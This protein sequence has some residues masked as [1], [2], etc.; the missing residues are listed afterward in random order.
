MNTNCFAI[1][2]DGHL[3]A[4]EEQA[5]LEAWR[6]RTYPIWIDFEG[7]DEEA[8]SAW[9]DQLGLDDRL[10]DLLHTG[11]LANK[12]LPTREAVFFAYPVALRGSQDHPVNFACLCL[13]GL[14]VTMQDESVDMPVLKA[15]VKKNY[16]LN[17]PSTSGLVCTALLLQSVSLRA[18]ALQLR[19]QS[20]VLAERMDENPDSVSLKEILAHKK[21]VMQL[22]GVVDEEMAVFDLLQN[23]HF[24]AL[25]L[26]SMKEFFQTA[27][28]NTHSAARS[29]DRLDRSAIDLQDRYASNQQDKTNSRLNVLTIVSAI[30]SP[31]TF[32]AGIYGMNFINM[33]ELQFQN[34]YFYTLGAMGVISVG[35][36]WYF[37]SRGWLK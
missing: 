32:I 25:D 8:A 12:I 4:M 18:L 14:V 3:E 34:G 5:A 9:L 36:L 16:K 17:E 37:L 22:D 13:E 24:P 15:M 11:G 20:R 26:V 2:P 33:P 28:S 6:A 1:H 21:Y 29:I 31:L 35:M 27:V 30:F 7:I 10:M 23:I 19:E